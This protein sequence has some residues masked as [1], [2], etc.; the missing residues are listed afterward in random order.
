MFPHALIQQAAALVATFEEKGLML[1]TAESCTGG[2]IAGCLTEVAGSSAVVERGFVTY[3]NNAKIELLGV[4][5]ALLQRHGAVSDE[6]AR[7]MAAGALTRS[8]AD[9]AVSAT[10][11]AGPGGGSAEKPIGLVFL[12]GARRNGTVE[13]RAPLARRF[14]FSGDRDAVR[15]AAVTA[16]L[17]LLAELGS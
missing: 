11:V 13:Q 2:L 5:P 8:P 1:V 3:S 14:V 4:P 12:G 10:G 9:L 16:A 6:V 15:L 7:A 17:E